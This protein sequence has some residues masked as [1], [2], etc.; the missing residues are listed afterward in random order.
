MTCNSYT[1]CGNSGISHLARWQVSIVPTAVVRSGQRT[2]NMMLEGSNGK[3][4][5][6][7]KVAH[8]AWVGKYFF[9]YPVSSNSLYKPELLARFN[10][11]FPVGTTFSIVTAGD[12][13][14]PPQPVCHLCAPEAAKMVQQL[15]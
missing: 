8:F 2:A 4:F 10:N 5:P 3:R 15:I 6:I 7:Y 9:V 11:L 12:P 1:F 14:A 13:P